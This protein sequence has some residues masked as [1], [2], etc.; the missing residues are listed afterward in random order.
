MKIIRIPKIDR[1]RE[2]ERR[3]QSRCGKEVVG[4]GGEVLLVGGGHGG[5]WSESLR[6][7][8]RGGG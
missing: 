3:L 1:E 7:V 2:R 4:K 5:G 6:G 8:K